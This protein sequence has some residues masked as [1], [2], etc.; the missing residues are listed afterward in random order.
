MERKKTHL[1]YLDKNGYT[2]MQEHGVRSDHPPNAVFYCEVPNNDDSRWIEGKP[3][4]PNVQFITL[5]PFYPSQRLDVSVEVNREPKVMRHENHQAFDGCVK[6]MPIHLLDFKP[7]PKCVE[8][9][10]HTIKP[11]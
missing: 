1:I 11:I 5:S 3:R 2:W 9:E 8:K 7:I 6:H 4:Q 10:V